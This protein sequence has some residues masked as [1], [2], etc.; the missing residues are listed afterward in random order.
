MFLKTRSWR[1]IGRLKYFL[2]KHYFENFSSNMVLLRFVPPYA[3]LGFELEE[4]C[5]EDNKHPLIDVVHQ[6]NQPKDILN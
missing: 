3:I 1:C 4:T 5:L 6:G 2:V